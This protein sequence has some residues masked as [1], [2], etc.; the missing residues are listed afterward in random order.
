LWATTAAG[1]PTGGTLSALWAGV[2]ESWQ[3]TLQSTWP[4]R[5]DAELL[6]FV[7]LLVVLA[8]VL[9]LELL[10]RL[11]NPLLALLPS[12]VVVVLSQ[13]Y[14][15]LTGWTAAAAALAYAAT[16]GALLAV[17]REGRLSARL[18][19]TAVPV[20][21]A[22]V[23]ALVAGALLPSPATQHSLKQN[24][25]APL[26][27]VTVASPLDEIAYRLSRPDSPVFEVRGDAGVDRW[28]V[29]VLDQFDGVNWTPGQQYL[30][31]GTALR[32]GPAVTVDVQQ[33]TARIES[34]NVGG[35]WLP[36]QTWPA[37]VSGAEPL[38]E[39]QQGS[40]LQQGSSAPA[41][42]TLTWWEPQIDRSA[43]L[44]AAIDPYAP[45]G[46]SG[47]GTVPAG[48]SELAERAVRGMRPSLQSALVL[49]Q[50]FR[51]EYRLATG[52][53]LPTGH[54][55]PQL[56]EFLLQSKRGTSE[57]FAAA[58]VALARI[59]GIPSRLAVGY[60]APAG[61]QR[62][63][64]VRNGDVYAWPEIAVEGVGW[65]QLDPM[66]TGSAQGNGAGS[67]LAAAAAAAREQLPAP[68]DLRDPAVAP[69]RVQQQAE[70][71]N[72]LPWTLLLIV[73]SGLIVVLLISVPAAK[74]IRAWGRK[75][76]AGTGKVIGAW[77][78]ARD[79]LRAHGLA[80]SA[81][82]TVRD[83]A[84]AAAG[85]SDDER[86]HDGLRRLGI[87]VDLALW[88]GA[89]SGKHSGSQ[90]WAA[91][92]DVRRGLARRGWRARLRAA[93]EPR[94]LMPPRG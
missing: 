11:A 92:R 36:S 17:T 48:I 81:G 39:E 54:S 37:A 89:P 29:V 71:G 2:T 45:G 79:R 40:L 23:C 75:R 62:D 30:R 82:M 83:L 27:P 72:P 60:R 5:P 50:F 41:G 33:R 87:T 1:L 85:I 56:T 35:E 84:N 88:S 19:S 6:L 3:L 34:V 18:P 74:A 78:E 47:V 26:V 51:D 66:G 94:T 53:S 42:Y 76:R 44:G 25:N 93:F 12:F 73:L 38:V 10:H 52:Q 9:G 57:Q 16:V 90:A 4:A 15:A 43:L 70:A 21:L 22:V 86:T 77:E 65:V 31:L 7:P 58:Y 69:P 55:W 63:Y 13:F 14:V 46:L 59:R 20:A 61:R 67:G 68:Q 80:V 8:G 28:P 24:R 91:V 64:T 49:E 32:P